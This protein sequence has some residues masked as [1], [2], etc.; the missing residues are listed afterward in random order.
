MTREELYQSDRGEREYYES[1]RSLKEPLKLPITKDG[2]EAILF[3]VSQALEIPLDDQLRI[4][5]AGWVHHTAMNENSFNFGDLGK[6]FWNRLSKTA[7]WRLDQ[8]AKESIRLAKE[9]QDKIDEG[10]TPTPLTI[11]KEANGES[12]DQPSVQ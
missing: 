7:T 12:V 2:C 8:D 4:D 9:A 11:A 10:K 5:F 3:M 1:K 6:V